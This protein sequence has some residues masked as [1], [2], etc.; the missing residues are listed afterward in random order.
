LKTTAKTN[1]PITRFQNYQIFSSLWCRA[2]RLSCMGLPKKRQSVD[3]ALT[4]A[5]AGYPNLRTL[6]TGIHLCW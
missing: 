4:I 5:K 2:K 3:I 1:Y 6:D